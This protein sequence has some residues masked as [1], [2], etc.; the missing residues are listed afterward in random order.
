MNPTAIKK[1]EI[2]SSLSHLPDDSLDTIKNYIDGLISEANMLKSHKGSL[3]G[4]W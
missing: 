1:M 2:I 3:K 4:I